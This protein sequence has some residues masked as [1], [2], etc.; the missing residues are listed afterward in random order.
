MKGVPLRIEIGPKDIEQNQCI[1]A[2]RDTGEKTTVSLDEL[3]AVITKTLEDIHK[4]LYAKAEARLNEKTHIA[5]DLPTLKQILDTTPGFVKAMWCGSDDCEL[6]VK[7]EA[8]ATSRC[9]PF[10]Q[11][12]IT[13]KCFV[14]GKPADKM[15]VWGRAY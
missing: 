6:R 4:N 9:I 3:E 15:V 12:K 8:T 5:Q 13:A 11:E 1:I 10:A 7:E 14:C 2:R